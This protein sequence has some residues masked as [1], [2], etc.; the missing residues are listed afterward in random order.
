MTSPFDVIFFNQIC[1]L[2][3]IEPCYDIERRIIER[4]RCMEVPSC[5]QWSNLCPTISTH[6]IDLTFIHWLGRQR[7]SNSV[8][9]RLITV[10]K[11]WGQCVSSPFKNHIASLYQS[12]IQKLIATFGSFS[13]FSTSWQ[14]YPALFI[15]NGHEIG[16]YLDI[17]NVA[18]ITM[19][20]K[21]VHE[22][23]MSIINK[24]M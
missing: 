20:L 1:S 6:I 12:F 5:I 4:Y 21:I 11:N 9:L 15:F 10:F 17:D 16:R 2:A 19:T 18:T 8:N 14:K 24:E 7:A 3:S 22:E 23:I 13:R